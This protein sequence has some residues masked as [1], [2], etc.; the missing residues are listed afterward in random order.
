MKDYILSLEDVFFGYDNELILENVNLKV[1]RSEFI[2]IIGLNGSGKSTLLKLMLGIN[3]PTKGVVKKDSN[4]RVG[5]VNQTTMTEEGS[6]PASVYEIVC[7]GLR[8]RPFSFI[9]KKE[10]NEVM[11]VLKKF[12]L[13]DL[14]NASLQSLSGGQ[15]QK[16]K[17]AKV[18]LSNPDIIILDEPTTGIDTLSE[19]MLLD[20]IDLLHNMKKTIILVSHNKDNL[21]KCD[22]I[23]KVSNKTIIKVEEV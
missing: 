13:Y 19:E 5:Y 22:D 2:G 21:K 7:L 23:Y 20:I 11:E 10:K 4:T 17:I 3:K 12:N 16:V 18:L 6:F 15:A 8:K 1:G 9:T 14:R